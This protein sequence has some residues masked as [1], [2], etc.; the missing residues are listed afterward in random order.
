MKTCYCRSYV[1]T[2]DVAVWWRRYLRAQARAQQVQGLWWQ[3]HL[4]A[5]GRERR[6]CKDG[7]SGIY[8]AVLLHRRHSIGPRAACMILIMV[9]ASRV[10]NVRSLQP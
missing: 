1:A 4:Q 7:G 3:W 9:P 5:R 8:S 6:Q 10:G 2:G